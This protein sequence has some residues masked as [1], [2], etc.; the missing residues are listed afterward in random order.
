MADDLPR[1]NAV[2]KWVDADGNGWT[3]AAIIG[4][5]SRDDDREGRSAPVGELEDRGLRLV[6]FTVVKP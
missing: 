4:H 3:A 1:Y 5:L 6:E 2:L